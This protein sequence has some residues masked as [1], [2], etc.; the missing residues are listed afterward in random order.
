MLGTSAGLA[1]RWRIKGSHYLVPP[2]GLLTAAESE[3]LVC[4]TFPVSELKAGSE[5]L[6]SARY[7]ESGDALERRIVLRQLPLWLAKPSMQLPHASGVDLS[8]SLVHLFPGRANRCVN[9]LITPE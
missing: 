2:N 9:T 6:P 5:M 4:L 3:E 7:P 8:D 1:Q